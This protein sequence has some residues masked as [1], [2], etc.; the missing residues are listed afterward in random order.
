MTKYTVN[1]CTDD[2][3]VK[4]FRRIRKVARQ[5]G[6]Y[7]KSIDFSELSKNTTVVFIDPFNNMK[8]LSRSI[9]TEVPNIITSIILEKNENARPIRGRSSCHQKEINC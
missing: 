8:C 1:P 5:S 2:V 6:M 9:K 7:I 3:W 4:V